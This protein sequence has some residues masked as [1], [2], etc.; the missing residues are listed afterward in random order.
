MTIGCID[1]ERFM[2]YH[3]RLQSRLEWIALKEYWRANDAGQQQVRELY[4]EALVRGLAKY[5]RRYK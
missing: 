1:V 2:D 3:R 5:N 4:G